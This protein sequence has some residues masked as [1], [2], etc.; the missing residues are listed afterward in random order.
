ML[1]LDILKREGGEGLMGL[2]AQGFLP[3]IIYGPKEKPLSVKLKQTDFL[4]VFEKA[5]ES[6][7]VRLS[8]KDTAKTDEGF[9]VLIHDVQNHPVTGVPIHVDFYVFEKGKKIEFS[10]PVEFIGVS[11]AV[12]DLAGN[13]IKVLHEVKILCAP[14][15]APHTLTVD[16]SKIDNFDIKFLAKDIVLPEG[17]SLLEEADEVVASVEPPRAD[18]PVEQAPIDLSSIEVEKKGK[19]EEETPSE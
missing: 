3:G 1:S 12:K 2:R 8:I 4:K 10:V 14:E 17:V 11:R 9:D 16:I 5:G 7:V 6:D 18:E 13:L 19:K 15:K